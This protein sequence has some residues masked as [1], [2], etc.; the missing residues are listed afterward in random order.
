[1]VFAKLPSE[2]GVEILEAFLRLGKEDY[3]MW[4]EVKNTGFAGFGCMSSFQ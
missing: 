3:N 1:M 4:Y 2:A